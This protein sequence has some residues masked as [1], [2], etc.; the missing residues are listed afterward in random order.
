MEV[1]ILIDFD[2]YQNL[3]SIKDKYYELRKE[4]KGGNEKQ[5]NQ[6]GEGEDEEARLERI[7]EKI[8]LKLDPNA[9]NPKIEEL[10]LQTI[11][12]VTLLQNDKNELVLHCFSGRQRKKASILLTSLTDCEDFDYNKE[13][14]VTIDNIF[15]PESNIVKLIKYVVS[16]H[17]KGSY[18]VGK[19]AFISKLEKLGL[20]EFIKTRTA[21]VTKKKEEK[22]LKS[23]KLCIQSTSDPNAP[24]IEPSKYWYCFEED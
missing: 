16:P 12:K 20:T 14:E 11:E 24:L 9:N 10:P 18:L 5:P 4:M 15:Y 21:K 13:K 3:L 6:I 17:L 22:G 1:K 2:E 23:K 8:L 19:D 7:V